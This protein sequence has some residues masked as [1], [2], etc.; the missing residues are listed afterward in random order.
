MR[1][2]L[3]FF[4]A[5]AL[6]VFGAGVTEEKPGGFQVL[7][8][9]TLQYAHE[10]IWAKTPA[11]RGPHFT[12]ADQ[13]VRDQPVHILVSASRFGADAAGQSEVNYRVVFTRP[14]GTPGNK[15]DALKLV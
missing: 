3:L 8:L 14:D 12:A 2:L 5:A 7:L 1:R 15:T 13:V 10:D 9:P 4:F 11:E 6:R